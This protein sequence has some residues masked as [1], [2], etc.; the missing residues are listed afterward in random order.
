MDHPSVKCIWFNRDEKVF[1]ITIKGRTNN[2]TIKFYDPSYKTMFFECD[3]PSYH[4]SSGPEKKCKH[5]IYFE[6]DIIKIENDSLPEYKNMY[7][8][9]QIAYTLSSV[10]V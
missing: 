1:V 9:L 4:Y 2:Y 6:K 8:K 5:M 7:N 3:C 10:F